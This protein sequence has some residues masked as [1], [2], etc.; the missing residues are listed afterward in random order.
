MTDQEQTIRVEIYDRVYKL[1]SAA[2]DEYTRRLAKSVDTAM[3]KISEETQ[4]VDSLRVA[5]LAAL[6]FADRYERLRE[7]YDK[8]SDAVVERSGRLLEALDAAEE[9]TSIG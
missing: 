3:R 8:L 6:N 5:V 2:Q 7:R 9:K 1:R 4:T